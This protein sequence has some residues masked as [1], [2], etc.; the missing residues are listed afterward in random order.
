MY[1]AASGKGVV[2]YENSNRARVTSTP[3]S[4]FWNQKTKATKVP[5]GYE[6]TFGL[7]DF[8][9]SLALEPIL[10]EE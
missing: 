2:P 7:R 4:R 10:S 3:L 9:R 1:D 8:Q 5:V 6:G